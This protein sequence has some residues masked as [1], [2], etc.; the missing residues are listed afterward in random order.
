VYDH[1]ATP[2]VMRFLGPV[3]TVDG[4]LVRP[5]DLH[6]AAGAWPGSVPVVVSRVASLGF[7]VRVEARAVDGTEVWAQL[8]R[9]QSAELDLRTGDTVHIGVTEVA[10]TP[11]L[12]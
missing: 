5:H 12:S 10:R 3:T 8:T 2:F 7:E 4:Q 6:V 1:P 11:V 9:G